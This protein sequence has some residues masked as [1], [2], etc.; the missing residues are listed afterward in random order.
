MQSLASASVFL[1]PPATNKDAGKH[2]YLYPHVAYG[3]YIFPARCYPS[4]PI[5]PISYPIIKICYSFYGT[6]PLK[7]YVSF[8]Y[9]PAT[10]CC[11]NLILDPAVMCSLQTSLLE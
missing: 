8:V 10:L 1:L 2:V 4:I 5:R 7:C 9:S 6:M 11:L 3:S